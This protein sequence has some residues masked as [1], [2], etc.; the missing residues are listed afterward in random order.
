VPRD[1]EL[2]EAFPMKTLARITVLTV[3]AV[4]LGLAAASSVHAIPVLANGGFESGLTSW[5]TG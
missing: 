2:G 5:T 4:V 3:V 1:A